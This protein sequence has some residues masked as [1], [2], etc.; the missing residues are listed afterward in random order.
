MFFVLLSSQA[1]ALI[2]YHISCRLSTTFLFF[3]FR[4]CDFINHFQA[5]SYLLYHICQPFVNNFFQVIFKVIFKSFDFA[6]HSTPSIIPPGLSSISCFASAVSAT[7]IILPSRFRIV[8]VFLVFY[9]FRTIQ[10][11]STIFC[12]YTDNIPTYIFANINASIVMHH[13]PT[14]IKQ[15]FYIANNIICFLYKK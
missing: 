1:T 10:T 2:D 14:G 4:F 3:L 6:F 11:I 9:L 12:F 7:K 5:T 13:Y 8:N 15:F